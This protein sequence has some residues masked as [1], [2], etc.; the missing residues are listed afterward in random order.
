MRVS[1]S[2]APARTFG[3]EPLGVDL[4]RRPARPVPR[5][6]HKIAS[7]GSIRT[8]RSPTYCDSGAASEVRGQ[9][10]QERAA[11]RL[12]RHVQHAPALIAPERSWNASHAASRPASRATRL[13]GVRQR[14]E[15]DDPAPIP[16]G[17]KLA[18]VLSAIRPD[19]ED[20]IDPVVLQQMH[21]TSERG[22]SSPDSGRRPDLPGAAARATVGNGQASHPVG[23]APEASS[24]RPD[25]DRPH[26]GPPRA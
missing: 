6:V 22:D 20:D 2:A 15:R 10:R 13:E 7:S 11:D 26:A 3:L 21:A 25:R 18:A 5:A 16:E 24:A 19:V 14:L 8:V 9:H 4:E 1:D 12:L 23:L 17:A